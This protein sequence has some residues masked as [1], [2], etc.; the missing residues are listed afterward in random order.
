MV[1]KRKEFPLDA[2]VSARVTS[3]TKRLLKKLK[4]KGHTENDIIEYG[5]L[6]LSDEP[7]LLDWEIGELKIN[8]ASL[9]SELHEKEALL[10]AKINRLK[11]IAPQLLD[12]AVLDKLLLESAKEYAK[13][14]YS[15]RSSKGLECSVRMLDNNLT[16][17]EIKETGESFGFDGDLFLDAVFKEFEKLCITKM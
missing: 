10:E 4:Q 9:K 2:Q 8:I 6:K 16:K 14:R 15:A 11:I 12:S 1:N 13:E 17:Q 3:K 5:A 7:L